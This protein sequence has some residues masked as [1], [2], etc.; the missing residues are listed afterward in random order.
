MKTTSTMPTMPTT[1]HKTKTV[2]RI[3]PIRLAPRTQRGISIM[4]VLLGLVI[5][6]LVAVVGFNQFSD[7]QRKARIEAATGEVSTIIADAQKTYGA[8]NQFANV[9]TAIAV[10]GGVIPAR[11]RD[12]G[13]N[14][15]RNKYSG[16]IF[17]TPATINVVNDSLDLT[18]RAVRAEDCQDIALTVDP[19]VNAIQVVDGS[20]V[21]P[22][23]GTLNLAT[24]AT[25]C[26]N[27]A[28]VNMIFRFGRQ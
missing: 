21:K 3:Q 24:L 28:T 14:T 20:F 25:Q 8:A 16:D 23:N 10:Q 26:A 22:V 27:T 9:T 5:A 11:L 17:L 15:A 6:A 4:S 18:Y 19:L 7:A 13:A 12:P 1:H 2:Q